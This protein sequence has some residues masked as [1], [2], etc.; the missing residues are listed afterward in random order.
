MAEVSLDRNLFASPGG[1]A[2][3]A[4]DP[5]ASMESVVRAVSLKYWSAI[6]QSDDRQN[7]DVPVLWRRQMSTQQNDTGRPTMAGRVDGRNVGRH[8][9]VL[10]NCRRNADA[11]RR[12]LSLTITRDGATV[13]GSSQLPVC[14]HFSP[15]IYLLTIN[16]ETVPKH[17]ESTRK[18]LF[19]HNRIRYVE[20]RNAQHVLLKSRCRLNVVLVRSN[21]EKEDD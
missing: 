15:E 19:L 14:R 4:I 11:D 16:S 13:A 3:L 6:R 12:L 20:S 10:P 21:G 18:T 17:V 2:E 8:Q 9:Q 5:V 7:E 1:E